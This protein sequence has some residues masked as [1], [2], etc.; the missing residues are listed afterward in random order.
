MLGFW[1]FSLYNH[2]VILSIYFKMLVSMMDVKLIT[3]LPMK[4]ITSYIITSLIAHHIGL[5]VILAIMSVSTFITAVILYLF[6]CVESA[7]LNWSNVIL[8]KKSG[9][10]SNERIQFRYAVNNQNITIYTQNNQKEI[11]ADGAI[12]Y[13]LQWN[14]NQMQI[15]LYEKRF[16]SDLVLCLTP[17]S[18]IFQFYRNGRFYWWRIPEYREKTT[19]LSQVTDKLYHI[20]LNQVYLAMNG[21]RT[22]KEC[23]KGMF[24]W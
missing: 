9:Q 22:H 6:Y 3:T 11:S 13:T 7:F 16:Q 23:S 12:L 10:S 8:C 21:S 5:S 14:R 24:Y 15:V 17:R 18:T 20:M 1:T 4:I 19:D 2:L